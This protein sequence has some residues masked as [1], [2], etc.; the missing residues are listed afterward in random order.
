ML[1]SRI[2]RDTFSLVGK[3]RPNH[4]CE[5]DKL[6]DLLHT[7][8]TR[9]K[10]LSRSL[11]GECFFFEFKE[12]FIFICLVDLPRIISCEQVSEGVFLQFVTCLF[13]ADCSALNEWWLSSWKLDEFI[14]CCNTTHLSSL[15][16]LSSCCPAFF[17]SLSFSFATWGMSVWECYKFNFFSSVIFTLSRVQR[18]CQK[19]MT[20]LKFCWRLRKLF[21]NHERTLIYSESESVTVG[22]ADDIFTDIATACRGEPKKHILRNL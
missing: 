4:E 16:F 21:F 3:I 11:L 17:C 9:K 2:R 19:V 8:W 14:Q 22:V 7:L 13:S 6:V 15:D 12:T 1:L 10:C 5:E 18:E 20:Q